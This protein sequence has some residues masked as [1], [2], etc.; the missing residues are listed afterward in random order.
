MIWQD[1]CAAVLASC[2]GEVHTALYCAPEFTPD[3]AAALPAGFAPDFRAQMPDLLCLRGDTLHVLD[4]KYYDYRH[5]FP[6]LPDMIKQYFYRYSLQERLVALQKAADL[7]AGLTTAGWESYRRLRVGGNMLLLPLF[8]QER[9]PE[10]AVHIGT[11][12]LPFTPSLGHIDVWLLNLQ[13]MM[14][15]YTGQTEAADVREA[16]FQ[17]AADH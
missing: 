4:A 2:Y 8:Q 1:M 12:R 5:T 15:A 13:L 7:P 14:A 9:A 11:L 17:L 3:S 16:F 6:A 10:T